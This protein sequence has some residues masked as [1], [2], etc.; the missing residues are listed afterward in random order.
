MDISGK[1]LSSNS[2]HKNNYSL[3]IS[4]LTAGIYFVEILTEN[5]KTTHKIIKN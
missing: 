5:T 2:N 3:D 1:K 4:H